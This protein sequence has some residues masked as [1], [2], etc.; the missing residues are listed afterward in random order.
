[1]L[2]S[3]HG[4]TNRWSIWIT[5]VIAIEPHH[6][7]VHAVVEVWLVV[8]GFAENQTGNVVDQCLFFFFCAKHLFTKRN[9]TV[10]WLP[11][12]QSASWRPTDQKGN[13]GG[14][15]TRT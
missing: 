3:H 15:N 6:C 13:P 10:D 4:P 5:V 9:R 14:K 2:H 8:E 11:H 12:F 7:V 1:M